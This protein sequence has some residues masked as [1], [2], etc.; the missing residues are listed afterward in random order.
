MEDAIRKVLPEAYR[1]LRIIA[2]DYEAEGREVLERVPAAVPGP[3]LPQTVSEEP[4]ALGWALPSVKSFE[5]G[6]QVFHDKVTRDS[7]FT[8]SWIAENGHRNTIMVPLAEAK[9]LLRFLAQVTT[10]P[11]FFDPAAP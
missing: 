4:G 10:D 1:D 5:L 3:G 7:R 9:A 8:L 2:A 6:T 11:R